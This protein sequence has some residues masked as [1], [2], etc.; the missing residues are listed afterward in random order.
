MHICVCAW[1]RARKCV[2]QID[3]HI[4]LSKAKG[5]VHVKSSQSSRCRICWYSKWKKTLNYNQQKRLEIAVEIATAAAIWAWMFG[6]V[7]Q[8]CW[9]RAVSCS[10]LDQWKS[11][12]GRGPRGVYGQRVQ[13]WGPRPSASATHAKIVGR[14]PQLENLDVVP[15]WNNSGKRSNASLPVPS[16]WQ[17]SRGTLNIAAA[18]AVYTGGYVLYRTVAYL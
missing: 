3:R 18:A 15:A 4:T 1:D 16:L 13:E 11:D 2:Y 17:C 5:L 7:I 9:T 10:I 8:L 14:Y 6:S 12:N